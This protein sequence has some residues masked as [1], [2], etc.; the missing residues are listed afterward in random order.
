MD[1][2]GKKEQIP[3]GPKNHENTV[4]DKDNKSKPVGLQNY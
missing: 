4:N 3:S 1:Y 2:G